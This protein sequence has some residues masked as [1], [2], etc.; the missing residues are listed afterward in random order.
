MTLP[1]Y[2][3]IYNK[4]YHDIMQHVPDDITWQSLVKLYSRKKKYI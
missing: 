1:K 4:Q 3:E 2:K